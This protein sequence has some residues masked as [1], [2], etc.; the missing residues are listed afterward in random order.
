MTQTEVCTNTIFKSARFCTNLFERLLDKLSRFGSPDS[1]A[2]IFSKRPCRSSSKKTQRL[3]DNNAC[4]KNFF[5]GNA[6]KQYNKTG[7]LI[8]TETTINNPKSLG[9][10][11]PVC[12]LQSYL[13]FGVKCND[14][15]LDHCAEVDLS[16]ISEEVLDLMSQ[17]TQDKKNRRV[18]APDLRKPRQTALFEQL[19]KP[20]Y[21]VDGFKTADLANALSS[22]FRNSAQIR[23]KR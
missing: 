8:R 17:P 22:D 6:I 21:F 20:K 10:N 1:I 15:L 9:L 11:K 3:Y 18:S 13:W 14:R 2:S 19:L 4:V 7:Y 16:T 12:Y 23:Y 5:R